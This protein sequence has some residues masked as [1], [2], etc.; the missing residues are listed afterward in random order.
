M[1]LAPY[2]IGRYRNFREICILTKGTVPYTLYPPIPFVPDLAELGILFD[3]ESQRPRTNP[4]TLEN[5][6]FHGGQIA[7]DI[8]AKLS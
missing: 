4:G 7:A 3:P 1:G 5:D 2:K 6:R 8:A